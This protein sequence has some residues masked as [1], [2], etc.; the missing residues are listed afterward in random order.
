MLRCSSAHLVEINVAAQEVER[1]WTLSRGSEKAGEVRT[2]YG[3]GDVNT[4]VAVS[5]GAKE[6]SNDDA[7][8][9]ASRRAAAV[10]THALKAVEAK[11]FAIDPL[12]SA[13][14]AAEGSTLASHV[15]TLKTTSDA[16]KK[17][18]P[19]TITAAGKPERQL[20]SEDGKDGRIPLDWST[21]EIY[22]KAQN[23]ARTLMDEPAN[24]MTP[25]T[26]CQP[27]ASTGRGRRAATS[28]TG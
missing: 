5:T 11:S 4:V 13:H 18:E 16:K 10:A 3:V 26:S 21:G 9:E 8:R 19:V 6:P 23:L 15:F 14:A 2:F 27:P 20:A 25:R 7:A 28:G 17:L 12:Y 22:A 24:R 1:L